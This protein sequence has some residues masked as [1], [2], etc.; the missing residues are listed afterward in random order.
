[1][2]RFHAFA[3]LVGFTL[4]IFM[5]V[6]GF[7]LSLQPLLDAMTTA[8]AV[9][10]PNVA[11]VAAQVAEQVP[12]VERL[13]RSASGQLVAYGFDGMARTSQIVDPNTGELLGPYAPS[14]V[15]AFFAELHRSLFL[16]G[17][18]HIVS[19]IA[20][21]AILVLS[22]SGI[23][24]LIRKM[25]GWRHLLGRARGTGSQRLHTNLA[26]AAVLALLLTATTGTY[27]SAVYFELVPSAE[28]GFAFAPVG[29]GTAPAPIA[30]LTGLASIPLTDLREL[31]FP[32][33][34]DPSDVF[35]ITTH[36]GLGYVDQA[37]GTTLSFTPN[38]AW[39][40]FYE[41]VYTLHTGEGAWMLAV[42]LG[43]GA[44]AAPA[45]AVTGSAIWWLRRRSIPHVRHNAPPR[46]ADT[47]ILVGSESGSTWGFAANLHEALSAEGNRVH[48]AAM[49]D[50]QRAYPKATR[51]LVLAATYGDGAAPAS[52]RNFLARLESFA[53]RPRFTVL[54]FG[55]R[56]F[57]RFCA[58]ASEVDAALIARGLEPLLPIHLIDRQSAADF[59][60]WGDNL[61]ARLGVNLRLAYV[62]PRPRTATVVLDERE[63]YGVEVQAPVVRLA[64]RRL[65]AARVCSAGSAG[66]ACPA[67]K[68][69]TLWA[70]CR[71]APICRAITH[72]PVRQRMAFSK[73]ACAS[74]PA[75]FA[76]S[77]CTP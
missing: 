10:V 3:G 52:A 25:G 18:G 26:R 56:N 5:A 57:A 28:S 54:G 8:P 30:S 6:T 75:A 2:R 67:T 23:V 32:A 24:L 65:L 63:L 22:L 15:F 7:V 29:E 72:S 45:L 55:D 62:P 38:S 35:T 66:G 59:A 27:L 49:N 69:V 39:Q 43:M 60:A 11:E 31:V 76:R 42:V 47:I 44:L 61:G 77:T 33:I 19:G 41:L 14:P 50:L 70:S 64:S 71:R 4:V 36:A 12:G 17:A 73:S 68:Q 20:S 34:D 48:L 9:G 21:F 37:T 13:V 16:G 53:S 51:L 40:Q 58:Y 1:M 46:D 74:G